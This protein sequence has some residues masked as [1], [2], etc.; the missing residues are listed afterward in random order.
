MFELSSFESFRK[1]FGFGGKGT[2][3]PFR[4]SIIFA[5]IFSNR[6]FGKAR[7]TS[8]RHHPF[9]FRGCL[10]SFCS[11][12]LRIFLAKLRCR[13]FRLPIAW[14]RTFECPRVGRIRAGSS[15][16]VWPIVRCANS[17]RTLCSCPKTSRK[18]ESLAANHFSPQQN[19]FSRL[20][21]HFEFCLM[22]KSMG[23]QLN[24]LLGFTAFDWSTFF[25]P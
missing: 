14:W 10:E 8:L 11:S 1:L 9:W 19:Y 18:L 15:T 5:I 21:L 25:V 22:Q 13:T 4:A 3:E 24:C 23:K 2:A 7:T 6:G 20:R 12:K 17:S 16:V